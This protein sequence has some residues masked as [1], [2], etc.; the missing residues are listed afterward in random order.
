LNYDFVPDR[1]TES[2][3]SIKA[4]ETIIRAPVKEFWQRVAAGDI[5]KI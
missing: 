1:D 5:P 4:L 2:L 3:R